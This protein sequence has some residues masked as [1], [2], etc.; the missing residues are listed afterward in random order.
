MSEMTVTALSPEQIINIFGSFDGNSALLERELDVK[1]IN[2]GSD[3]KVTGAEADA[4]RA[5]RVIRAL[6]AQVA[7]TGEAINEQ[8]I[9]YAIR[10]VNDNQ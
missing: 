5:V 4:A 2:R 6:L 9:R 10:L 3:I 7:G 8:N 1:V